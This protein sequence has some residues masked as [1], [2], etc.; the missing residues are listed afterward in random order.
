MI[1]YNLSGNA[2]L[3]CLKVANARFLLVDEDPALSERIEESRADIEGKLGSKIMILDAALKK[4][5]SKSEAKRPGDELRQDLQ[6]NW[7]MSIF[8]TR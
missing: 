7:P 3:H 8:Y 6:G 2:L 1:N 5:L 4:D